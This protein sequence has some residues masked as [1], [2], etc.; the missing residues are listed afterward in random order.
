MKLLLTW[1]NIFTFLF[2]PIAHG[3]IQRPS[4]QDISVGDGIPN[5]GYL[6]SFHSTLAPWNPDPAQGSKELL[7]TVYALRFLKTEELLRARKGY[8][9]LLPPGERLIPYS[10]VPSEVKNIFLHG[11]RKILQIN[12]LVRQLDRGVI[13]TPPE[14]RI[15]NRKKVFTALN[16]M[17][18]SLS[19]MDRLIRFLSTEIFEDNPSFEKMVQ[20]LAMTYPSTSY[21]SGTRRYK[22]SLTERRKAR[23]IL[24]QR[25]WNQFNISELLE[26][27]LAQKTFLLNQYP[28]LGARL[29]DSEDHCELYQCLYKALAQRLHLPNLKKKMSSAYINFTT[30]KEIDLNATYKKQAEKNLEL[31]S[32][33]KEEAFEEAAP[34]FDR[35]IRV[36][37]KG[38]FEFLIQLNS[39]RFFKDNKSPYLLM[40]LNEKNWES[41][42]NGQNFFW[43][44]QEVFKKGKEEL[45]ALLE[46]KGNREKLISRT[47]ELI[48][49]G[50]MGAAAVT[51]LT[52]WGG[53]AAM[54]IA[55]TVSHKLLLLS[56]VSY[57]LKAVFDYI[58]HKRFS[59]L[60]SQLYVANIER[61]YYGMQK[62]YRL[63]I[64]RDYKE[65]AYAVGSFVLLGRGL[66]LRPLKFLFRPVATAAHK[67]LALTSQRLEFLR[68]KVLDMKYSVLSKFSYYRQLI[69]RSKQILNKEKQI[70][71]G[72]SH[73]LGENADKL[74]ISIDS[75]RKLVTDN[76]L[77][78]KALNKL[79]LISESDFIQREL[80]VEFVAVLTSE[81]LVRK[82]KFIKEFP[83]VLF[84]SLFALG[85]IFSIS[86]QTYKNAIGKVGMVKNKSSIWPSK[87][88]PFVL[89]TTGKNWAKNSFQLAVPIAWVAGLLNGGLL[90]HQG[91]IQGE[92]ITSKDMAKAVET[93]FWM[94]ALL[95]ITSPPRSQWVGKR[96]NPAID[97]FYLRYPRRYSNAKIEKGILNAGKWAEDIKIPA[98]IGNNMIGAFSLTYILNR[99]G[100]QSSDINYDSPLVSKKDL[101]YVY[102]DLEWENANYLFPVILGPIPPHSS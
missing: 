89:K 11:P 63:I 27:I 4:L 96:I 65:V 87:G 49:W 55:R 93:F 41:L 99:R 62:D 52:G 38:N 40:A 84:N 16:T 51:W 92:E 81:I 21:W 6:D 72:L 45:M 37:I 66:I 20:E 43:V 79:K 100:I 47:L 82:D 95:S 2:S 54:M 22:G 1:A 83:H 90:L 7:Q 60:A 44:E 42:L 17:A 69:F 23:N 97:R 5:E 24:K 15:E 94:V 10:F 48:S 80:V 98:S 88:E 26:N 32:Q 56:G 85:V 64:E 9:E 71:E 18:I 29:E 30:A 8:L 34:L 25:L 53:V 78:K 73:L 76:P 74:K 3:G 101:T 50:L 14:K 36:A 67:T 58:N 59:Q 39:H 13:F 12:H 61:S 31:L 68:K 28:L 70:K 33:Y 75:I 86:S 102:H 19:Q 91:L 35:A 77:I 46:A 57:G